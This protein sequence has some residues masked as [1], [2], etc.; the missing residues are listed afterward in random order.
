[1]SK[2]SSN[3]YARVVEA[4]GEDSQLDM[5]TEEMA[6]L[7]QA[8]SK[9]RRAKTQEKKAKA[10]IHLCEEVADVENMINQLRYMLDA[11]LIDQFKAEK[12]KRTEKR[13]NKPK[14]AE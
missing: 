10:Y 5:M 2:K 12:L 6:E 8:I 7:I 13:L 1:M 11:N 9:F 3:I 14:D 4:W